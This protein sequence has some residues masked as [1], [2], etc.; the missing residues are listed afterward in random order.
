MVQPETRIPLKKERRPRPF[1]HELNRLLQASGIVP[2]RARG[3]MLL[4]WCAAGDSER[5]PV[6]RHGHLPPRIGRVVVFIEEH[7]EEPLSLDRMADEANLSKYHFSRLFREEVGQ[8]PWAYVREERVKKAKTLLEQ[9]L[10]PVT[11]AVEA[12]FFDQSH[13]TKVLKEVEGKTPRQYQKEH[14]EPG[15]KDLQ[16]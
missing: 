10:P 5:S 12:G 8:S 4:P 11:A 9:G 6:S 14:F 2:I 16:E 13:F 15:R 1:L 7:L 3:M